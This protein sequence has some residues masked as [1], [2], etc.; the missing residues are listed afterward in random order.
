[1]VRPSSTSTADPAAIVWQRFN[2]DDDAAAFIQ[3]GSA[4]GRRTVSTGSQQ[5]GRLLA[6]GWTRYFGWLV[7]VAGLLGGVLYLVTVGAVALAGRDHRRSRAAHLGLLGA[8]VAAALVM[9]LGFTA[10]TVRTA[11]HQLGSVTLSDRIG[12]NPARCRRRSARKR[13]F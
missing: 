12:A 11:V 1:M 9:T 5:V 4:D 8:S 3:S 2:R 10:L 6:A 7:A 13:R